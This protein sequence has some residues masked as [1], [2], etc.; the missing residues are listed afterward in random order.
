MTDVE[1][2]QNWQMP[3][4]LLLRHYLEQHLLVFLIVDLS[5]RLAHHDAADYPQYPLCGQA[6]QGIGQ[7][8]RG[9]L[10]LAGLQQEQGALP[11]LWRRPDGCAHRHAKDIDAAAH[12]LPLYLSAALQQLVAVGLGAQ[13]LCDVHIL[14]VPWDIVIR[15][16]G[17][18]GHHIARAVGKQQAA[19]R[20]PGVIKHADIFAELAH[21]RGPVEGNKPRPLHHQVIDGGVGVAHEDFGVVPH[22]R[23]VDVGQGADGVVPADGAENGGNRPVA[24]GVHQVLRPQLGMA[25]HKI[26]PLQ[27]V[28]HGHQL[29]LKFLLQPLFCNVVFVQKLR[30]PQPSPGETD[31]GNPVAG[32]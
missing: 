30:V 24:K 18:G 23:K 20:L 1:V 32:I 26:A 3:Q 9:G 22:H 15:P 29:Q 28:R 6:A 4:S 17:A 19:H 14:L 31:H 25:R 27:S 16:A 7:S 12:Q 5:L 13:T 10:F 11:L 8:R 2:V 21:H